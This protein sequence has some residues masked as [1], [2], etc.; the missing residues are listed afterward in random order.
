MSWVGKE[1]DVSAAAAADRRQLPPLEDD[2]PWVAMS[3][4]TDAVMVAEEQEP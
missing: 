4:G 3:G 2:G 1:D